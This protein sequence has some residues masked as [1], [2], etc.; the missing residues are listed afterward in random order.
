MPVLSATLPTSAAQAFQVTLYMMVWFCLLFSN[1]PLAGSLSSASGDNPA[2]PNGDYAAWAPHNQDGSWTRAAEH[3][4]ASSTLPK[5]TPA[6]AVEFCP[7]Y[8]E[9]GYSQRKQFW[10]GLLSAMSGPES[11]FRPASRYQERFI[12][13]Q[14]RPVVSRGLLQIS[15]ESANQQ[16]YGCDIRHPSLLHDPLINLSCGVRIL[17]RWVSQDGLIASNHSPKGGG[18]YWSTLRHQN[19]KTAQIRDFTRALPFCRSSRQQLA[20]QQPATTASSAAAQS[21]VATG[22]DAAIASAASAVAPLQRTHLPQQTLTAQTSAPPS[23]RQVTAAAKQ[24]PSGRIRLKPANPNQ[25]R[26]LP[27]STAAGVSRTSISP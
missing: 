1:M 11:N 5:T 6:D 17:A 23:R 12:D 15:Q 27:P 25:H 3:A 22:S 9:L 20:Q 13:R 24:P 10:V 18:R 4:V 8:P 19:G 14:G 16:R 2:R 26:S 7:R 21:A